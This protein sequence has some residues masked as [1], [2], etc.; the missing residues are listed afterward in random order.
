MDNCELC[1]L[2][3]DEVNKMSVRSEARDLSSNMQQALTLSSDALRSAHEAGAVVAAETAGSADG[4][5]PARTHALS[6]ASPPRL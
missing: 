2:V 4:L 3:L 1:V 5:N 6:L